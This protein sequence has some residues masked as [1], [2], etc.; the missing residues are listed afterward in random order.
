VPTVSAKAQP[1]KKAHPISGVSAQPAGK[2]SSKES[3]KDP[4]KKRISVTQNFPT[5]LVKSKGKSEFPLD[6]KLNNKASVPDP[7]KEIAS[8][9]DKADWLNEE[10]KKNLLGLVNSLKRQE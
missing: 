1:R 3:I 5:S 7:M 8:A 9:L 2:I 6:A 10:F 4:A